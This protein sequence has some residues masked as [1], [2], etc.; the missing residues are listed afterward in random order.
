MPKLNRIIRCYFGFTAATN[1]PYQHIGYV[2]GVSL[3][4]NAA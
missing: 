4:I 3:K 1:E 2:F